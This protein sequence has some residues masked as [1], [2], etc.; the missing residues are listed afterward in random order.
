MFNIPNIP[1][2][3]NKQFTGSVFFFRSKLTEVFNVVQEVNIL[4]SK[5][6][7]N[8]RLLKRPE[9]GITF[10]K[11][12]CW[13]LSQFDKCVFLDADTL[14]CYYLCSY[15]SGIKFLYRF[16]HSVRVIIVIDPLLLNVTF[17]WKILGQV[18]LSSIYVIIKN[19]LNIQ[20]HSCQS[21]I[22]SKIYSKSTPCI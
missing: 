11:L 21:N 17:W 15:S 1:V 16:V 5:D 7:A 20:G 4:D 18:N 19:T 9:L 8:L 3:N 2:Y 13:R 6:E 12:H 10:T 14:V 22:M